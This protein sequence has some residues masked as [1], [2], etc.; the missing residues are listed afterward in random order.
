MNR[1]LQEMKEWRAD[2]IVINYDNSKVIIAIQEAM[3]DIGELDDFLV[4]DL[5]Y[6]IMSKIVLSDDIWSIAENSS[7]AEKQLMKHKLS[8]EVKAYILAVFINIMDRDF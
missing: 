4:R 6:D 8:N 3:L 1:I 7:E 5:E 2:G